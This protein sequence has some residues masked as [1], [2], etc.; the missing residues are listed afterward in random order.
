MKYIALFI[1]LFA[2]ISLA[3]NYIV[4]FDN[5]T[6]GK[7]NGDHK[8]KMIN[9]QNTNSSNIAKLNEFIKN[10]KYK[11]SITKDLW[12]IQG[13]VVKLNEV[14]KKKIENLSFV[15]SVLKNK[16]RKLIDPI[17][18]DS[19]VIQNKDEGLWGLNFL[20]IPKIRSEFPELT[21]KGVKVGILDTGIQDKHPEFYSHGSNVVFKDFVNKLKY[22]YDDNGHGTH[23]AGIIS[24]ENTGV[25]P[26]VSIYAGKILTANGGGLDSWILEG[27]QWIYDPDGD[28]ET[29]DFP[30]IVN[31]SWGM[32]LDSEPLDEKSIEPYKLAVEA[33]VSNGIIPVFAA[34]NS[35]A[36]PVGFPAALFKTIA[37][38]A[39]DNKGAITEFS[40]FGP[41]LWLTSDNLVILSKPDVSAPGLN[42]KSSIPNNTHENYSGTSMAAPFV[43]GSIALY[44]QKNPKHDLKKVKMALYKTVNKK[45]DYYHGLGILNTYEFVK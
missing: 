42:I 22:P 5:V 16:F 17:P 26:S 12:L 7:K 29:Y 45:M 20:G 27:M 30:A 18:V 8:D 32:T 33:W 31:N 44:L 10:E 34:G 6:V 4:L 13:A 23:V 3:N 41:N 38:G 35:S 21:G 19:K 39:I 11:T 28:P 36:N 40:S 15:R 43:A 25:A 24:G 9:M 1:V 2:N 37:V 14:E